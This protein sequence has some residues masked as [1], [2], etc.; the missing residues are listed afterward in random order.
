VASISSPSLLRGSVYAYHREGVA[1]GHDVE[2]DGIGHAFE[3]RHK[4]RMSGDFDLV[5]RQQRAYPAVFRPEPLYL[6]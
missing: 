6:R 3:A 2:P 1:S 5:L 4:R